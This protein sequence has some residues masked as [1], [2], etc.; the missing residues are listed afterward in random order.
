MKCHDAI[1]AVMNSAYNVLRMTIED[2]SD[3]DLLVRPVPNANHIAWQMG[4]LIVSENQIVN[5][6]KPGSAPALPEGFAEAYSK[7]TASID[8]PA[9]FHGKATYLKLYDEQR[10]AALDLLATMSE[11]DFDRPA[12][13]KMRAYAPTVGEAFIMLGTHQ[14]MH[15][16]QFTPVRRKLNKSIL[17]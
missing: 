4:H 16:G 7:E 5:G 14:F 2:L 11:Q 15:G 3:A 13:D 17:F 12:P 10:K 9:R 6:L 8:D 1:K